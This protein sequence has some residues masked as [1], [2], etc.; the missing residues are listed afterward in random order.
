MKIFLAG[1]TGAIGRLL[2]PRLLKAGH[3]VIGTT[4]TPAKTVFITEMGARPVVI[5]ALDREALHLCLETERPDVVIH[6]MT[7]LA[8]RDFAANTRLRIEGSR[9]LVDAAKAAGVQRMI[10]ESIAWMYGPGAS[11]ASEDEALDL[12]ATESRAG[13]VAAVQA[14]EQ[15]VAEMPIGVVLRYGLLY[16]PATW[17]KRDSLT[18]DQLKQGQLEATDA[19]SSFI[20]VDDAAQAALEALEW[21]AGIYNIVDDEP[22]AATEWMTLYAN[23]VGAPLPS[24]KAG[25]ADWERG[26]ANAKAKLL[27]W[28]PQ[29]ATWREGFKTVLA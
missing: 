8:T 28:K 13:S 18:T 6:Q 29:Y 10:A 4:R 14:L 21:P 15:A 2:V 7:D 22:A 17:Y 24:I 27:G 3:D 16:G 9:N 19:V 25:K 1:A 11:P 12:A 23:L 5:D 26:A 20:H